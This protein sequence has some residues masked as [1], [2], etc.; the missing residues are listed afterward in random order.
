ML[1]WALCGIL[2]LTVLILAVRLVLLRR[3]IRDLGEE[4]DARLEADTN[5]GLDS[6]SQDRQVRALAARLD[7]ALKTLRMEQLRYRQ[8]DR[9][10]KEAVTNISHDLRTPLTAICG[11]L[12]LLEQEE[13]TENTARYLALIRGRTQAMKDLTEEL[14]S[15]SLTAA[16]EDALQLELVDLGAAVEESMAS[17]Y[18]A[19]TGRGILPQ[20]MLPE[21]KVLRLL[22]PAALSRVLGNI[23][24]NAL[25]YSD[26]DLEVRL[27]KDGTLVV[28]NTASALSE[29]E[30]GRLFD[31]FF[32]VEAAR[33]ST[34]LGLSIA[35]LLTERMGGSIT[36]RYEAGRLSILLEFPM[37]VEA[38]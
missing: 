37:D 13:Q 29:V 21:D 30:V 32:T 36:S 8:G 12:E 38:I 22:D 2:T 27:T 18:E 3:D 26:G 19:F 23:L 14:F 31:R 1:L 24:N 33:N 7:G 4:I 5:V 25:K 17:F 28:S 6:S 10:V 20:V 35:K 16:G 34:G 9:E 15:Y 11:Y